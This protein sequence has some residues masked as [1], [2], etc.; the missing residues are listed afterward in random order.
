MT[1]PSDSPPD[2]SRTPTRSPS[3]RLRW[4]PLAAAG[5]VAL[6]AVVLLAPSFASWHVEDDLRTMRWVLEYRGEPW[7]ALVELHS[8]HDHVRPATLIATWAGAMLSDGAWWGPHLILVVLQLAGLAGL[9]A[10][11]A[12]LAKNPLAGVAAAAPALTLPGYEARAGLD[13]WLCPAG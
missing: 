4:A 5:G 11:A 7:V 12:R 1:P 2:P 10:L 13:A 9:G 6:A 8:L 3:A